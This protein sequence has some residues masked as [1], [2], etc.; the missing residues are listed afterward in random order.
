MDSSPGF[1]LNIILREGD[2]DLRH[3]ETWPN[4]IFGAALVVSIC[5]ILFAGYSFFIREIFDS[6]SAESVLREEKLMIFQ[7]EYALISGREAYLNQMTELDAMFAAQAAKMPSESEVAE[8]IEDIS[9]VATDHGLSTSFVALKSENKRDLYV[10]L[11]INIAVVGS[12]HALGA[13]VAG[14]SQVTRLVTMHDFSI[15]HKENGPLIM[16]LEAKTYRFVDSV[17]NDE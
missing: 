7:S 4:T 1:N 15:N 9:K 3:L 17:N 2:F 6:T 8:V 10:E 5:L 11:P 14:L 13:F 12:Y 16:T